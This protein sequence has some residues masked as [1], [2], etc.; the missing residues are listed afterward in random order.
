MTGRTVWS[1]LREIVPGLVE[2]R[3]GTLSVER[4]D[5]R[6]AR[7]GRAVIEGAR[8][9]L[10]VEGTE[11]VQPGVAYVMMSNHASHYDVP[12]LYASL[13]GSIRMVAKRELF[14]VPLFGRAMRAA[15]TIE[16]DRQ[17]HK[18]AVA[19]LRTGLDALARGVSIWI[20]PEGTRSK[21]GTLGPLK[22]GGF[23]LALESGAPI[24][25]IRLEG[26]NPILPPGSLRTRTGQRVHVVV[27]RPIPTDGLGPDARGMLMEKVRAFLAGESDER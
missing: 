2:D 11:N 8:I 26:T 12:I 4:T 7:F 22:K 24:L 1:L 19:S 5:E 27:G 15:G 20:A 16:V 10:S 6:L 14:R 21:K 17:D 18:Q 13:P 25:P 23:M 3:F 9:T